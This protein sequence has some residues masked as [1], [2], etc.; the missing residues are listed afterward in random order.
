MLFGSIRHEKYSQ[1]SCR[2]ERNRSA[3][4]GTQN[5]AAVFMTASILVWRSMEKQSYSWKSTFPISSR[6]RSC[7]VT[8]EQFITS[9]WMIFAA[10]RRVKAVPDPGAF[11]GDKTVSQIAGRLK[12]GCGNLKPWV[13]CCC[14]RRRVRLNHRPVI[15]K[16]VHDGR[17]TRIYC[18]STRSLTTLR[19]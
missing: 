16:P 9:S 5:A 1:S 3:R 15:D 2:K 8:Q 17:R 14:S 7:A 6:S 13:Y 19:G 11:F 18:R 4:A 10:E 12:T